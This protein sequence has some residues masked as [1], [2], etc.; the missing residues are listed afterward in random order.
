VVPQELQAAIDTLLREFP[1]Q[2]SG[3]ADRQAAVTK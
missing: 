2:V 1:A 3:A